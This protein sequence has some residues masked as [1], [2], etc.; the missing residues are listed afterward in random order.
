LVSV[1]DCTTGGAPPPIWTPPTVTERSLAT[2]SSVASRRTIQVMTR[3]VALIAVVALATAPGAAAKDGLSFSR[4]SAHVGDQLTLSSSWMTH[5]T[6]VVVY[7]LPLAQAPRWWPTYQALAPAYGPPPHLASA[8]RLGAIQP[9]GSHG[10]R[11]TFRVPRV[12]P[13]RYVLGFW[14]KPCNTHW[15]SALPNY[16]VDPYGVLRVL[17][18]A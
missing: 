9:Y 10:G 5:R 11:L 8:V 12:A 13:G 3:L 1:I 18:A 15:T 4:H 2:D 16:Q 14:C 17:K 6:G 7:L